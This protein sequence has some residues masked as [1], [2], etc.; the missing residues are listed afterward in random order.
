MNEELEDSAAQ[1]TQ[2]QQRCS[3]TTMFCRRE[4]IKQGKQPSFLILK[5]NLKGLLLIQRWQKMIHPIDPDDPQPGHT[6]CQ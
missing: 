2:K 4:G 3:L 1:L 6:S 5:R